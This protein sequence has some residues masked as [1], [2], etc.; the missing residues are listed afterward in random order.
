MSQWSSS[1][2]GGRRDHDRGCCV[3]IMWSSSPLSSSGRCQ[4][5]ERGWAEGEGHGGK[6]RVGGGVGEGSMVRQLRRM[7][8]TASE[9]NTTLWQQ[10]E[11]G[12][13]PQKVRS[14]NRT[15]CHSSNWKKI[16]PQKIS[17]NTKQANIL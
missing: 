12:L 5:E 6:D 16:Q 8:E 2:A 9:V 13:P 3:V 15:R 7:R 17:Q 14:G 1:W 4:G 10:D 11:R